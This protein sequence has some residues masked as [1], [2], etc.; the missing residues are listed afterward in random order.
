[1]NFSNCYG[2][3]LL[4]GAFL[5]FS[6]CSLAQTENVLNTGGAHLED[7]FG[8]TVTY[9][10]GEVVIDTKIDS[11]IV[12]TQ[13]VVQPEIIINVGVLEL[14]DLEVSIYPNPT[15][16]ILN[17]Q[18]PTNANDYSVTLYDQRGKI[19]Q[20]QQEV[21]S[22]SIQLSLLDLPMAYYNLVVNKNGK[23]NN[24]KIIKTR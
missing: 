4:V 6:F 12:V 14:E 13:G 17:I 24:Y 19:L 1:M 18:V 5:G 15:S 2:R 10:I 7:R 21:N 11:P 20:I 8:N 9:G 22:N 23:S 3:L 16:N